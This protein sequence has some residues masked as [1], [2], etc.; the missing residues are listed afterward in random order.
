VLKNKNVP[1][2]QRFLASR[3]FI[4]KYN[5]NLLNSKTNI[6]RKQL[7]VKS[8]LF[9]FGLGNTMQSIHESETE[10]KQFGGNWPNWASY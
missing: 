2:K 3:C 4:K 10:H 8:G 5:Q 9:S 7:T 1:K 6:Q